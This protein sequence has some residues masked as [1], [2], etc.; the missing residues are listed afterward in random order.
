MNSSEI[1]YEILSHLK[2][3]FH[4]FFFNSGDPSFLSLS[5]VNFPSFDNSCNLSLTA[6]PNEHEIFNALFSLSPLKIPG[7]DMVYTQL[8]IKEIGPL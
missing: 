2:S 4:P 5:N 6:P 3:I 1:Q 7:D 8:F